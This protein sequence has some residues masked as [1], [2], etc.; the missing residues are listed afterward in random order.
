MTPFPWTA[1]VMQLDNITASPTLM[2]IDTD[3]L[4]E[5]RNWVVEAPRRTEMQDNF[6]EID[7]YEFALLTHGGADESSWMNYHSDERRQLK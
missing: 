6:P 3:S 5:S 4:S 7:Q 2:S 1:D